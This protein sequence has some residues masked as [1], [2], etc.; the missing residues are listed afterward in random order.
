MIEVFPSRAIALTLFGFSVHWYG[1]MYL[2]AFLIAILLLPRLQRFR[3]LHLTRDEW[4]S[5]VSWGIVGV[6]VGGRLGYVFFYEPS[7]FVHNPQKILAVWEG[8]MSFHGGLLG[9]AI[10]VPLACFRKKISILRVAD[11]VVVPSAIG[12][13]LGRLGN[14]INLEL[15]GTV[16]DLPWGIAIP[17]VE[18]LRHPTQLYAMLKDL[19]IASLC[20]MHLI[21]TRRTF[22]PGRTFSLLLLF[23]GAGRFLLEY[24]R[25]QQYPLAHIGALAL[26]RGQLLTL[27]VFLFGVLL[28]ILLGRSSRDG[29]Q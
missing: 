28:W 17:G 27:P 13:A 7:Y 18:G 1:V 29:E 5:L 2:L 8:G 10:C 25:E 16:T 26:T 3:G 22:I 21:R 14:F 6:I 12:L 20:C 9:V 4:M 23:Y 15:Y 24:V 11:T 19:T